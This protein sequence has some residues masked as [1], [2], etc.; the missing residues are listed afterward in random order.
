MVIFFF[1]PGK[2]SPAKNNSNVSFLSILTEKKFFLY[3]IA[4]FIFPLIDGF[5][6]IIISNF[7]DTEIPNM[8]STMPII[9]LLISSLFV[10]ITGLLCDLIGRKKIIVPGFISHWVSL[11]QYLDLLDRSIFL[12]IF[13][14]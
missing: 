10:L 3:F 12:G 1:K 4:W 8:L 6:S 5:E 14:S 11:T 9:E 7:L 13:T 2:Q